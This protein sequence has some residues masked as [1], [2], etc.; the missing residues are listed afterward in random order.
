MVL[1]DF[2]CQRCGKRFEMEVLEEREAQERVYTVPAR[3]PG[4]ESTLIVEIRTIRRFRRRS[5]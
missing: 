5:A 3:C 2:K 4:C 1:K